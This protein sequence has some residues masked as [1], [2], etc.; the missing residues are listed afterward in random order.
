MSI[1]CLSQTTTL[2]T[3]WPWGLVPVV[4]IVRGFPSLA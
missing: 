3:F 4:V 2:L 1:Y